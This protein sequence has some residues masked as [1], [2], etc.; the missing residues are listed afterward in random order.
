MLIGLYKVGKRAGY[1]GKV[2]LLKMLED[3]LPSDIP[4]RI[5]WNFGPNISIKILLLVPWDNFTGK[6][7]DWGIVL[8]WIY[9]THFS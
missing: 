7:D 3:P 5:K 8:H 2:D 6:W 4:E 9:I 1:K